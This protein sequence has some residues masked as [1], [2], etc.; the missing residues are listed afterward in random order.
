MI[1]QYEALLFGLEILHDMGVKHVEAN[2][3]SLLVV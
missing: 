3:N 1:V 2:G